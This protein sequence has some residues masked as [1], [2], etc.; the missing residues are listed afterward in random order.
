DIK[1]ARHPVIEKSL[2]LAEKYISNNL[3]LDN[4][5]DQIMIITGPNMGGKSSYLRQTAIIVLLA[6]LGCYVPAAS[7]RISIVDR[8]FVRAGASDNIAL[9]EST[10]M[11]EML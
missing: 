7:A 10:F 2:P 8:I 3:Y 4:T 11:V 6:Q 1:E 9:G 5:S